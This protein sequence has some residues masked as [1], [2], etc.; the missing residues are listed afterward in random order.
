[1]SI[2]DKRGN[3]HRARIFQ[4]SPTQIYHEIPATTAVGKATIVY[5]STTT[6]E[7]STSQIELSPISPG[8]MSADGSGS[9]I[10][11]ASVMRLSL[12][13]PSTIEPVF[14]SDRGEIVPIPIDVTSDRELVFLNISGTGFHFISGFSK[15][16]VTIGGTPVQVIYAGTQG[17]GPGRDRLL[18]ILPQGL[19][20]RGLVDVVLTVDGR[21]ANPVQLNIK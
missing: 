3:F 5:R 9:W 7:I 18:V 10:A 1:V 20:G 15:V 6:D 4:V 21:T 2:I 12:T 13:R 8:L 14:K 17:T 19:S 16:G 11:N